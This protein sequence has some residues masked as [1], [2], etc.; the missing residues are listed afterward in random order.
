MNATPYGSPYSPFFGA[1]ASI[2]DSTRGL[3]NLAPNEVMRTQVLRMAEAELAMASTVTMRTTK[4][5]TV[6][7]PSWFVYHDDST[8]LVTRR[9]DVLWVYVAKKKSDQVVKLH[10][11]AGTVVEL[12][13]SAADGHLPHNLVNALPHAIAG[14][15]A[16]WL[17]A[18]LPVLAQEV[19]RRRYTMSAA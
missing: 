12:P 5:L 14:Y 13:M 7:G 2:T 17:A 6:M 4:G 3:A 9:E 19:D 15:D 1:L 10:L 16:R 18:P 11:R 8:L